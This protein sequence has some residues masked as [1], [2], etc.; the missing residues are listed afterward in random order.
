MG[1]EGVSLCYKT[2]VWDVLYTNTCDV[3]VRKGDKTC[4][5]ATN[6]LIECNQRMPTYNVPG[7]RIRLKVVATNMW[8]HR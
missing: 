8:T 5:E 4:G 6:I 2:I 1:I 7:V 3:T